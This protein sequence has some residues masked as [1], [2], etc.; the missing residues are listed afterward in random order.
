MD[1]E[2]T[3]TGCAPE[4]KAVRAATEARLRSGYVR[5][6]S[7]A[8]TVQF[9]LEIFTMRATTE[10]THMDSTSVKIMSWDVQHKISHPFPKGNLPKVSV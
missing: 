4:R 6:E 5:A 8:L 1:A 9:Y 3:C 7:R 10:R 2:N